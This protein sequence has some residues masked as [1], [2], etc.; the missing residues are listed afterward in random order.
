MWFSVETHTYQHVCKDAYIHVAIHCG[1]LVSA[2]RSKPV[3]AKKMYKLENIEHKGIR[4]SEFRNTVF[5]QNPYTL[6]GIHTLRN[7]D[8]RLSAKTRI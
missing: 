7:V 4:P 1:I 3:N 6:K 5:G 8:V 2:F